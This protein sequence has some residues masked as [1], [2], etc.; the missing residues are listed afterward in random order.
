MFKRK[1][2]KCKPCRYSWHYLCCFTLHVLDN[3]VHDIAEGDIWCCSQPNLLI[4]GPNKIR[5]TLGNRRSVANGS[6]CP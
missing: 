1:I 6:A 4:M 3:V 5:T 2:G